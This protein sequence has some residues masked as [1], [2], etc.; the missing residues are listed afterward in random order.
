MILDPCRDGIEIWYGNQV[1]HMKGSVDECVDKIIKFITVLD[2]KGNRKQVIVPLL[3]ICGDGKH[4]QYVFENNGIE[5]IEVMAGIIIQD[6]IK[7]KI[8]RSNYRIPTTFF[9]D[10]R[11]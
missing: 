7:Q 6:N 2:E 1:Q 3:D 8:I 10:I 9:N 11:Y 5:I 4:W